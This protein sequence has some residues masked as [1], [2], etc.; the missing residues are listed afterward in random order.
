[1]SRW[2]GARQ[3]IVHLLLDLLVG[4]L[5]LL[6]VRLALCLGVWLPLLDFLCNDGVIWYGVVAQVLA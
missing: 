3:G 6:L 2:L 1:M 4:C 5:R